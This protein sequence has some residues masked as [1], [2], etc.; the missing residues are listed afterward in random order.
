MELPKDDIVW[1]LFVIG[2]LINRKFHYR[3]GVSDYNVLRVVKRFAFL[4]V[5]LLKAH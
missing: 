2:R 1:I 4:D 3:M 5:F